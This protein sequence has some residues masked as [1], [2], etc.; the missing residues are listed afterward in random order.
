MRPSTKQFQE[1]ASIDLVVSNP[2]VVEPLFSKLFDRVIYK[3]ESEIE[4]IQFQKVHSIIYDTTQKLPLSKLKLQ[5]VIEKK[6]PHI[7]SPLPTFR[8]YLDSVLFVSRYVPTLQEHIF[9]FLFQKLLDMDARI[10]MDI[11]PLQTRLNQEITPTLFD[12]DQFLS[13]QVVSVFDTFFE[14]LL[15]YLTFPFCTEEKRHSI[16]ALRSYNYLFLQTPSLWTP[17]LDQSQTS[18]FRFQIDDNDCHTFRNHLFANSLKL[19]TAYTISTDSSKFRRAPVLLVYICALEEWSNPIG[20]SLPILNQFWNIE[21]DQNSS[22]VEDLT[23]IN[24]K[25][26]PGISCTNHFFNTFFNLISQSNPSSA[27]PRSIIALTSAVSTF[28]SR[29]ITLSSPQVHNSLFLIL[30]S[31]RQYLHTLPKQSI[32]IQTIQTSLGKHN[33]QVL[34]ST[35]S[36]SSTVSTIKTPQTGRNMSSFNSQIQ[37]E[38]RENQFSTLD[39]EIVTAYVN[40]FLLAFVSKISHHHQTLVN[41]IAKF[42]QPIQSVFQT[43]V[44]SVRV[45]SLA[46]ITLL[47][48]FVNFCSESTASDWANLL[49]DHVRKGLPNNVMEHVNI[50]SSFVLRDDLFFTPFTNLLCSYPLRPFVY[51]FPFESAPQTTTADSNT[52]A[53]SNDSSETSLEQS[54]VTSSGPSRPLSTV[55]DFSFHP[56]SSTSHR[57]PFRADPMFINFVPFRSRTPQVIKPKKSTRLPYLKMSTRPLPFQRLVNDTKNRWTEWTNLEMSA[58]LKEN[59]RSLNWVVPPEPSPDSL[60][61]SIIGTPLAITRELTSSLIVKDGAPLNSSQTSTNTP[62]IPHLITQS[63]LLTPI[64]QTITPLLGDDRALSMLSTD[65][66]TSTS[67]TVTPL[68]FPT[69]PIVPSQD[70]V[71]GKKSA[72][73]VSP[74]MKFNSPATP[75]LAT[76]QKQLDPLPVVPPPKP[77]PKMQLSLSFG[78]SFSH[79]LEP[80]KMTIM[81]IETNVTESGAVSAVSKSTRDIVTDKGIEPELSTRTKQEQGGFAES[82]MFFPTESAHHDSQRTLQSTDNSHFDASDEHQIGLTPAP[83]HSPVAHTVKSILIQLDDEIQQIAESESESSGH[84]RSEAAIKDDSDTESSESSHSHSRK[85]LKSSQPLTRARQRD[86]SDEVSHEVIAPTP[87]IA[88]TTKETVMWSPK[89]ISSSSDSDVSSYDNETSEVEYDELGHGRGKFNLPFTMDDE[90]EELQLSVPSDPAPK[91]NGMLVPVVGEEGAIHEGVGYGMYDTDAISQLS[92]QAQSYFSYSSQESES[93]PEY[94]D[95]QFGRHSQRLFSNPRKEYQRNEHRLIGEIHQFSGTPMTPFQAQFSPFIQTPSP[96]ANS[97]LSHI[98]LFLPTTLTPPHH[99]PHV[100]RLL[101][102]PPPNR[103]PFVTLPSRLSGLK[104][105]VQD[106]FLSGSENH[107]S[108]KPA[109]PTKEDKESQRDSSLGPIQKMKRKKSEQTH[110]HRHHDSDSDSATHRPKQRQDLKKKA[111]KKKWAKQL[112]LRQK[113][114]KRASSSSFGLIQSLGLDFVEEN[115]FSG[116][117]LTPNRG[118]HHSQYTPQRH[119]PRTPSEK[120][121]RKEKKEMQKLARKRKRH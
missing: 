41:F 85:P 10:D 16:L 18:Q 99:S 63:V 113:I 70:L 14:M 22:V 96:F 39:Q 35:P 33:N 29:M 88:F 83:A 48:R 108:Q 109:K 59:I 46:D 102:T 8:N 79:L 43:D 87:S 61:S 5:P 24:N 23:H 3:V 21:K 28:T 58:Q 67:T 93:S 57:D 44:D 19:W 90:S 71:V 86:V 42:K 25:Q 97:P 15:L 81:H 118:T 80:S 62:K 107:H 6:F 77:Q 26:Q 45:S 37:Q 54:S 72:F 112:K 52:S 11:Q 111:Q 110:H 7:N 89:D 49:P 13:E 119:P 116:T 91:D 38:L 100:Q 64:P 103:S 95:F 66:D 9:P 75:S 76:S 115:A 74:S 98:P 1:P 2:A 68:F 30:K 60:F 32:T 55:N 82:P 114:E 120:R 40:S 121:R 84:Q 106:Q 31:L 50:D 53:N 47:L 12:P 73:Q 34:K 94:S 4:E 117:R 78:S 20:S 104:V 36:A 69:T 101:G 56:L 27:N 51:L 65:S 105:P 17:N 92:D